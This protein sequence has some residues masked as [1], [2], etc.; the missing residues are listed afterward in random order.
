MLSA[1]E[2]P[3]PPHH[4]AV[5]NGSRLSIPKM[6]TGYHTTPPLPPDMTNGQTQVPHLYAPPSHPESES[7]GPHIQ[8]IWVVTGPA[9]SG[10]ST[11]GED[12]NNALK[13]PFLEGDDYHPRSNKEKMGA[14]IPLTDEDR[15]DWLTSLREA[16]IRVLSPAEENHYQPPDGVVV[17]CSALKRKYRDVVRVAA[18]ECPN[19]KIHFIYLKL[20][21]E[22]LYDRLEH[23]KSHYMKSGMVN[24]QLEILEEPSPTEWDSTTVDADAPPDVVRQR[25]R[26]VVSEKLAECQ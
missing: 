6:S 19:V 18:Y 25:V 17:A 12:I 15:W 7:S 23:R 11:V 10:K 8:H 26:D 4:A 22:A 21:K 20:G 3:Q 16:A 2:L 13:L 1:G 9:G 14:G 5:V 24:S